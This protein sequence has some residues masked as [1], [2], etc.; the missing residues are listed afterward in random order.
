MKEYYNKDNQTIYNCDNIELLKSLESESVDLIYCD[1]LYNT[2]KVFDD[3]NDN[4]EHVDKKVDNWKVKINKVSK[5]F[6]LKEDAIMYIIDDIDSMYDIFNNNSKFSDSDDMLD[7]LI[8][9]D[10]I[11]F[12]NTLKC[13]KKELGIKETYK[14]INLDDDEPE[15]REL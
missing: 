15:F 6:E 3:Y 1:I 11:D 14:L 12:Y 10:S 5:Y 13:L 2:G 8:K 4:Y 7:E 9:Q